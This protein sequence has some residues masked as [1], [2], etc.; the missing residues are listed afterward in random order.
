MARTISSGFDELRENLEITGLQS[1][2]V[3]TRQTNVRE[4]VERRLAVLTSFLSGSY[5]RATM[6]APLK[7]S[8]IDITVILDPEYYTR[9]K[10]AGLLDKVHY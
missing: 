1:S 7:D 3:S 10:P 2:T 4:A 9:F 8:D 6:I 5:K